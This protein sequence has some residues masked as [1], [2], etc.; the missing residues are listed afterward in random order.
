VPKM[1]QRW[2]VGTKSPLLPAGHAVVALLSFGLVISMPVDSSAQYLPFPPI[3]PS[4]LEECQAFSRQVSDYITQINAEH[5]GCLDSHKADRARTAEEGPDVCS[6]SACQTLHDKIYGRDVLTGKSQSQALQDAVEKCTAT[7]N[8]KLKREQEAKREEARQAAERQQRRETDQQRQQQAAAD[9]DAQRKQLADKQRAAAADR[10]AQRKAQADT[11]KHEK[12]AREKAAAAEYAEQLARERA[13]QA[14]AEQKALSEQI[15]KHKAEAASAPT[16]PEPPVF[17]DGSAK[18]LAEALNVD[19]FGTPTNDG[20][21]T[22]VLDAASIASAP[23]PFG[24]GADTKNAPPRSVSG[25]D[26]LQDGVLIRRGSSLPSI[27]ITV[28]ARVARDAGLS[29]V[30]INS[31]R[32]PEA[33]VEDMFVNAQANRHV[34]YGAA[35]RAVLAVYDRATLARQSEKQIKGAMLNELLSQLP[36]AQE[37]GELTHVSGGRYYAIDIAKS[38]VPPES[39]DRL[40]QSIKSSKEV[41]GVFCGARDPDA[42]HIEI[43]KDPSERNGTL[44]RDWCK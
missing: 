11:A 26:R 6:R 21:A 20:R 30:K 43:P 25:A 5:Q 27:G 22:R 1:S 41:T 18:Q 42:Y 35:G 13:L 37:R 15:A 39:R 19:P 3:G 24:T 23:N 14:A 40:I 38:S 31:E 4:S 28:V 17:K 29:E 9:R 32:T 33:Q 2:T 44:I 7:V 34:G 8:E 12:E 16:A 36:S 10:E